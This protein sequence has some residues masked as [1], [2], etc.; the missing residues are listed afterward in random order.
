MVCVAITSGDLAAIEMAAP[1]ADLFEVRIDLIGAG[2]REVAGRLKKPWLACNRRAAE[3]GNWTGSEPERVAELL[4][5]VDLG[6]GIV[7]IELLTPD[8]EA[9]VKS[10]KGKAQCLLSYHNLIATP[11]PR[12]L[13]DIVNGQL[14]AGADICKVVT[15]ARDVGDNITVLQIIRDFP[16][17]KI[18]AFAMGAAGQLSRVLSPLAGGYFTYA[19]AGPGRESA[20][21]QLTVD[22]LKTI[23]GMLGHD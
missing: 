1:L 10:I 12:A 9:V 22:E 17:K 4:G 21:G 20:A 19:S 6:A 13:R 18:V 15:T 23:Y 5:A 3:G 14:A 8:R 16:G 11:S 2:W 7:D